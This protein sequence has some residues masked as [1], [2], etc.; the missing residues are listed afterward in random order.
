MSD[1]EIA[2][3]VCSSRLVA[4]ERITTD[5]VDISVGTS[6]GGPSN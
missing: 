3:R 6:K 4:G 2:A 5:G 1:L